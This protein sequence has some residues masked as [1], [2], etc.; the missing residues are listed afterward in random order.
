MVTQNNYLTDLVNGD[1][2]R[3]IQIGKR[4]YRCGLSFLNVEVQELVSRHSYNILLI[5]EILYSIS[6]NLNT[7]QHK[8]LMIDF[9]NRMKEKGIRQKDQSF[10]DRMLTDPYLNALKVVYGY[11]LTCH[12]SQ[13]GEWNEVFLYLDN[14]IQGIPKPGIYQWLYTAVTR[15]IKTLHI[16][17]DWFIK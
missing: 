2:I 14:K 5:E 1:I 15:A 8:D 6:T 13:G 3:V 17:D 4:E 11:A 16:V 12:K 9:F 10:K 7:K